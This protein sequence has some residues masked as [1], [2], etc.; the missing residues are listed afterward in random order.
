[1]TQKLGSCDR[2]MHFSWANV[3]LLIHCIVIV[4][5]S[6]NNNWAAY[7]YPHLIGPIFYFWCIFFFAVVFTVLLVYSSSTRNTYLVC[8]E[9]I[10]NSKWPS[11]LD[12]LLVYIGGLSKYYALYSTLTTMYRWIHEVIQRSRFRNF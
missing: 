12:N 5:T 2:K 4:A 10:V 3:V 9:I 7:L 1:M 8:G 11:R 6:W